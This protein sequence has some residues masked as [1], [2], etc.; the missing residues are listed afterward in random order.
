MIFLFQRNL[1]PKYYKD[2]EGNIRVIIF[3]YNQEGIIEAS[4]NQIRQNGIDKV[5]I[6]IRMLE[7]LTMLMEAKPTAE[8][9]KA[10]KSQV[11]AI[12]QSSQKIFKAALDLSAF[13]KR[14]E[15]F[16]NIS[17]VNS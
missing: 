7:I 6:A 1:P 8:F 4:F 9:R 10:L 11:E 16:Q 5:S 3:P 15:T 13:E 2:E 14:F 17:D 12:R